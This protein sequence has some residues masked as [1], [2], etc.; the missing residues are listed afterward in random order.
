MRKVVV[1]IWTNK[2]CVSFLVQL[3]IRYDITSAI[4]CFQLFISISV[5]IYGCYI[6]DASQNNAGANS[7]GEVNIY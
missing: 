6:M 7:F 4:S 1:F 3:D 5:L 2:M